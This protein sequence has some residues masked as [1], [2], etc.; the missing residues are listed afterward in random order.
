MVKGP[1][2]MMPLVERSARES[3][4]EPDQMMPSAF[5]EAASRK[6]A[7]GVVKATTAVWSSTTVVDS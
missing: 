4:W 2:P 7:L 3:A 6:P 1:E 5:S